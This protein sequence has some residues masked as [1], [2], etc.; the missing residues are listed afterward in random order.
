[1]VNTTLAVIL[2]G[3]LILTHAVL[4]YVIGLRFDGFYRYAVCNLR[5]TIGA[6]ALMDDT[7]ALFAVVLE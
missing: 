6:V 7:L 3:I 4:T 1:M 5:A 2:H